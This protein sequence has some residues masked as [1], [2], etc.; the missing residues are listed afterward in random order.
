MGEYVDDGLNGVLVEYLTEF[1]FTLEFCSSVDEG[2]WGFL[3]LLASHI[4][5]QVRDTTACWLGGWANSN[6]AVVALW[7]DV[8]GCLVVTA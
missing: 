4:L 3:D 5:R 2:G 1:C 6:S 8:V 7:D